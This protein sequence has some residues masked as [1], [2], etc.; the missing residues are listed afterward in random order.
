[1]GCGE[2]AAMAV[3]SAVE[4]MLPGRAVLQAVLHSIDCS[5]VAEKAAL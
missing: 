1:M 3:A 2:Q 4:A 5:K